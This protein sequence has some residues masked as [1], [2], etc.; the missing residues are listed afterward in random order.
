MSYQSRKSFAFA[1]CELEDDE[2]FAGPV[3][4][5]E[6]RTCAVLSNILEES[7]DRAFSDSLPVQPLTHLAE[8]HEHTTTLGGEQQLGSGTVVID[9]EV[10]FGDVVEQERMAFAQTELQACSVD[11]EG[12]PPH[13]ATTV[14]ISVVCTPSK[15]TTHERAQQFTFSSTACR[16]TGTCLH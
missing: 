8:T 5:K 12:S 2:V 9:D 3:S 11:Q 10:F 15:I 14:S 1:E 7:T 13:T 4:L 16:E 6:L